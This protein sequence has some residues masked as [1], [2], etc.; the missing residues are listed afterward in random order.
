VSEVMRS[1]CWCKKDAAA[2]VS[3]E[4]SDKLARVLAVAYAGAM[5]FNCSS[6]CS[7]EGESAKIAAA[8]LLHSYTVADCWSEYPWCTH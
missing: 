7:I 1:S 2:P 3:A 6:A 5:S 4:H 8:R